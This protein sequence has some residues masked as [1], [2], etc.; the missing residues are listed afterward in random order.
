MRLVFG[1]ARAGRTPY[2]RAMLPILWLACA[3]P[4]GPAPLVGLAASSLSDVLPAVADDWKRAGGADITFSFDA[5]SRLARQVEAG[6]PADLVVF[7]DGPTLDDL[8]RAGL[9]QGR[10][11]LLGNS[12]VVVVPAAAAWTPTAPTDL[13]A[14]AL[15]HLALAAE[16]VPAG[17]YGRAALQAANVWT[18]VEPRVVSG[19]NVR[20]TLAW[21]SRN[22]AEAGVVYATDATADPAVRV[23][24]TF[25]ATSHPPIV[26]PGAV[27]ASS[28]H[29]ADAA[30]FLD[31]CSSPAARARFVAAGFTIPPGPR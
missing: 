27:V 12:L 26:Y 31:Y 2:C 9:V 5:S 3:S 15:V 14:P 7:A 8:D 10:R 18:D 6:A 30:A 19:D 17:R 29:A 11:D 16:A 24:F 4:E 23:A 28:T 25:P 13:A 22:E 1:V 21:V 20:T